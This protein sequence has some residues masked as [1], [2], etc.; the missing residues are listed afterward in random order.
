[1]GGH[2]NPRPL[3]LSSY[4]ILSVKFLRYVLTSSVVIQKNLNELFR[5]QLPSLQAI[6]EEFFEDVYGDVN[7]KGI[8][9]LV[10]IF[11]LTIN[12]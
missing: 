5:P 9:E 2:I 1:M 12:I 8:E 6:R 7:R 4:K 3:G 10:N 11:I